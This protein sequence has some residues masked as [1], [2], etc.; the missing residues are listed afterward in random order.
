MQQIRYKML[1]LQRGIDK[2]IGTPLINIL[3]LSKKQKN[4]VPNKVLFTIL[5]DGGSL[6]EIGYRY[7][8][9]VK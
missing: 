5:P 4:V 2:T 8:E 6:V 1:S 9:W 3:S 7:L